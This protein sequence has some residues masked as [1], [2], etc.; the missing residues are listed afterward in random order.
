MKKAYVKPV[1]MKAALLPMVAATKSI[2]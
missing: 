2:T 1:L